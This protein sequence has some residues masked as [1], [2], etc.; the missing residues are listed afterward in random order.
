MEK[1]YNVVRDPKTQG[2]TTA[3]SFIIAIADGGPRSFGQIDSGGP[4]LAARGQGH[5]RNVQE[6]STGHRPGR[7][8][9]VLI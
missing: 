4:S 9:V 6:D 2:A 1:D 3:V 5:D 8:S 7:V